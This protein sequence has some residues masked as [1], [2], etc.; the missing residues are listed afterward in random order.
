M[1]VL[2]GKRAV[3]TGAGT[4][5]GRAIAVR[6]AREGASVALLGR[7]RAM[8]DETHR[9]LAAGDHLVLPTDVAETSHVARAADAIRE[10]WGAV[11]VL[12]SNAGIY[13]VGDPI[14]DEWTTWFEPI[15]V[16]LL[17]AILCARAFVPLMPDGGRIVVVTSVHTERVERGG[18]AYATAKGGLRQYM[19]SLALELADRGILV[20]AVAPG[21]IDTP[22]A[23]VAEG[24]N[25]LE[26]DWFRRDYVEGHHLPLRRA[27]RADE[28]AGAVLFLAGPDASYV[29]GQTITV[30]GGLTIT[31]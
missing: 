5:I 1:A 22:M 10:R 8:L 13:R 17:G 18:S 7:R 20:N 3:I 16:N 15:R 4:G 12:V 21:F 29:T 24:V 28:V 6:F 11:D 26:S 31:F 25:E 27:G 9:L 2:D 23:A 30:D 14:R 19:R